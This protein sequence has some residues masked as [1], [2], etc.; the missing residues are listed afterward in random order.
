MT[1]TRRLPAPAGLVAAVVAGV[2]IPA[3][4]RINGALGLRLDDGIAAALTSFATGL[5]VLLVLAA[6]LPSGRA[7][8]RRIAPAVREGGI[9]WW[10]LGAGLCG[11]LFVIGQSVTVGVLG[12]AVFTIAAV[13]GQTVSG[14]L[15]DRAG[16]AQGRQRPLTG[17]RLAATLLTLAS[18]AYAVTPKLS[19][20]DV[21]ALLALVLLPFAGGF[22]QS[23]QSAMNGA[24]AMAYR[25]PLTATLMNFASGTAGLALAWG[26]KALAA[27]T[28][29]PLPA[30]S[31]DW[32]YYLGG[33]LGIVFIAAAAVLVRHIGVLLTGL[34]MIAGQLLGSLALDVVVPAPGSV[35]APATV[36]GT[37][38]TL[39]AM[40]LATLPWNRR[41]LRPS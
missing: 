34:G 20:I 2:A 31:A 16:F 29:R 6:L 37:V 35:V 13:T 14:L 36:I 5:V 41:W 8:A 38:A 24:S 32:W 7:G 10:Y 12:I 33:P 28:G 25:S 22:S 23:F 4:G 3:Q 17:M 19:A 27:G 40:V 11:A 21:G 15:V 1:P 39:A 9:P 18:V 30:E 26:V